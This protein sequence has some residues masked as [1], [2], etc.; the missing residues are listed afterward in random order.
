MNRVDFVEYA[1]IHSTEGVRKS[2]RKKG[3]EK[4]IISNY[5]LYRCKKMAHNHIFS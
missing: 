2:A 3:E 4:S 5:S 1:Q